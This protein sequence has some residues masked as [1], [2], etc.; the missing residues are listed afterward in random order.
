MCT[1]KNKKNEMSGY[2][3][4]E[5]KLYVVQKS[6]GL[7]MCTPKNKKNEMSGYGRNKIV[8]NATYNENKNEK[9]TPILRKPQI[10]RYA[11]GK[12]HIRKL[13]RSPTLQP[14]TPYI[15]SAPRHNKLLIFPT[16]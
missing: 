12:G 15:L 11:I 5:H 3:F 16:T 9:R 2:V 13:L 8:A 6:G 7:S 10:S 4:D 14:L 1:P